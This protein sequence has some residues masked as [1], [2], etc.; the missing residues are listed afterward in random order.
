MSTIIITEEN[1]DKEVNHSEIPVLVDFW[2][3]WCKPC[4]TIA[5]VLETVSDELKNRVKVGKINVNDEPDL[6]EK[7]HIK[8]VPTMLLFRNGEVTDAFMGEYNKEQIL[9]VLG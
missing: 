8:S 6:A 4:R 7:Y 5:P 3:N 1:F 2:A 9:K